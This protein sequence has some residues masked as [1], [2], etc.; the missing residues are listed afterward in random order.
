MRVGKLA[1]RRTT[2]A[3]EA[4]PAWFFAG[5]AAPIYWTLIACNIAIPLTTLWFAKIRRNVAA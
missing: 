4:H 5:P 1:V 2:P 3:E